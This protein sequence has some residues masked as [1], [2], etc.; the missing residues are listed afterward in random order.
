MQRI[1]VVDDDPDVLRLTADLLTR[2]GYDVLPAASPL[3]ALDM[4]KNVTGVDLMLIDAV[5]P[6]MSGPEF[7]EQ[8]VTR[9]PAVR[10][11]FMTGLDALSV[12]LAFGKECDSIQKPFQLHSLKTKV[13]SMLRGS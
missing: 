9:Y 2:E 1:L 4:L 7:A 3:Q 12:T 13:A 6:M 8:M 5:L 11:L 10:I